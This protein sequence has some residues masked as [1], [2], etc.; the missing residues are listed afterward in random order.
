MLILAIWKRI[1]QYGITENRYF[2]AVL[3]VWLAAIAIYFTFSRVKNI[4]AIPAT[5]CI[6]AFATSFGPWGAYSVSERSQVQ[7][8]EK[9]LVSNE[10]LVDGLVDQAVGSV[11]L[12]DRRE[13][14][15]ILRYIVETHGPAP[16]APWFGDAYVRID[17][18]GQANNGR[19]R[20]AMTVVRDMMAH[21]GLAYAGHGAGAGEHFNY[22]LD[23]NDKSHSI[24]NY[25][26]FA[27]IDYS[28]HSPDSLDVGEEG[29]LIV[30]DSEHNSVLLKHRGRAILTVPLDP[31]FEKAAAIA[32]QG[33]DMRSL[34]AEVM[35]VEARSTQAAMSIYFQRVNGKKTNDVWEI[36]SF[37]ANC[38]IRLR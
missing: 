11:S 25:D 6:V 15:A 13:I 37:D 12:D 7:R 3:S 22:V 30:F 32:V 2:L 36:Q 23:N 27:G 16:I 34:P 38:F 4:K 19:N 26:L 35:H 28:S 31:L 33:E 29:H 21:M 9:L 17:S 8:L 24:G 10:I 18:A 14:S 1:S 20:N 5:L